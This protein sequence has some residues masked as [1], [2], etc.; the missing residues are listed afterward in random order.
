MK[1]SN[2]LKV[3]E[4][5]IVCPL[6]HLF[7]FMSQ[8]PAY[9]RDQF[10]AEAH[11][12]YLDQENWLNHL[13]W[14]RTQSDYATPITSENP[15]QSFAIIGENNQGHAHSEDMG[16]KSS[17]L[18]FSILRY[19]STE[20]P[21]CLGIK[22]PLGVETMKQMP[23]TYWSDANN[24]FRSRRLQMIRERN[25][26]SALDVVKKY[27]KLPGIFPF[28]K[29]QRKRNYGTD[30]VLSVAIQSFGQGAK[31]SRNKGRSKCIERLPPLLISPCGKD[32]PFKT[33]FKPIHVK[34]DQVFMARERRFFHNHGLYR[35]PVPY[36]HR[37][38]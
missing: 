26:I 18:D 12:K 5:S 38:F 37:G 33:R 20:K 19:R 34:D 4:F 24:S 13:T 31:L 32:K 22:L 35:N 8:L 1:L 21:Y 30:E 36:N 2:C 10:F 11:L 29:S 16:E 6:I 27:T 17:T 9:L 7:L 23:S 14:T 15:T 28:E 25:G 3:E